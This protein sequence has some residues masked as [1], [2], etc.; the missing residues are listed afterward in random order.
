M[1]VTFRQHMQRIVVVIQALHAAKEKAF[2]SRSSSV[3]NNCLCTTRIPSVVLDHAV[4]R[5]S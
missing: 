1:L 3:L 2:S 5:S 4:S